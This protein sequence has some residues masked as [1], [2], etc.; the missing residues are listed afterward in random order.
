MA[1]GPDSDVGFPK[2]FVGFPGDLA[3]G[4]LEVM[5]CVLQ[6]KDSH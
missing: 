5:S 3:M 2:F 4:P 1:A 6:G